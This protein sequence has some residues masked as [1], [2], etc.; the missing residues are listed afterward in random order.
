MDILRMSKKKIEATKKGRERK[1]K[2]E[3]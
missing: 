3:K 2:I 1:K